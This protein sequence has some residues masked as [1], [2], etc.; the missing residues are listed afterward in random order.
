MDNA[1]SRT[2]SSSSS[3]T[4][5]AS[6]Q[7]AVTSQRQGFLAACGVVELSS[8]GDDTVLA[9]AREALLR[10]EQPLESQHWFVL[11]DSSTAYTAAVVDGTVQLL[12]RD[13]ASG[14]QP[15][16]LILTLGESAQKLVFRDGEITLFR[17]GAYH[18][19][20]TAELQAQTSP[21]P[22]VRLQPPFLRPPARPLWSTPVQ[23]L[24][25]QP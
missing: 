15:S 5:T 16:G 11:E 4:N 14:G 1:T 8:R 13:Q 10:M 22:P 24:T 6:F 9:I 12:H 20:G 7:P 19:L 3:N 2:S 25:P 18:F 21:S 17:S 23:W